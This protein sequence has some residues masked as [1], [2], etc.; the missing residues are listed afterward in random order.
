MNK[1]LNG[2]NDF[3]EISQ[4]IGNVKNK[5]NEINNNSEI[6]N[7]KS[8]FVFSGLFMHTVC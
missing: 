2:N 4:S 7:Y 6:K 5:N 3:F 8:Y 1:A